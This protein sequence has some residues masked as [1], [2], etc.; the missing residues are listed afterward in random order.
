MKTKVRI[1]AFFCSTGAA[2]ADQFGLSMLIVG[3]SI[4]VEIIQ[5]SE[6]QPSCRPAIISK[7]VT[8]AT[9]RTKSRELLGFRF[10]DLEHLHAALGWPD[11]IKCDG[12]GGDKDFDMDGVKAFLFLLFRHHN[13]AN[14]TNTEEIFGWSY[15]TGSRAF[16]AAEKWMLLTHG[17]RLNALHFFVPRFAMYVG[18]FCKD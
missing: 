9:F 3:M 8:F 13:S 17:H 12:G 18:C 15:C 11:T 14:L 16:R 4:L 10:S 6:A 5:M 1:A 7:V 2:F